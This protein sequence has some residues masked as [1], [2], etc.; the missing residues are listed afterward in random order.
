MTAL[1]PDVRKG[2][3]LPTVR[4]KTIL[5]AEPPKISL[6]EL[7]GA[8]EKRLTSAGIAGRNFGVVQIRGIRR[9]HLRNGEGVVA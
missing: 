3:A 1:P 9:A 5:G 2:C 7:D 4:T 6:L 8:A